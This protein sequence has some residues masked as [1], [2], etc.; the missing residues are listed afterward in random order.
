MVSGSASS[1]GTHISIGSFGERNYLRLHAEDSGELV[2][3]RS[4]GWEGERHMRTKGIARLIA[5]AARR[6]DAV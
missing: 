2:L 3:K 5:A 6:E 4:G 1:R